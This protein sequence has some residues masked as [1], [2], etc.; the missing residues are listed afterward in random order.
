MQSSHIPLH[1]I[2]L[3]TFKTLKTSSSFPPFPSLK[4]CVLPLFISKYYPLFL[5]PYPSPHFY[6]G[7]DPSY[8][9]LGPNLSSKNVNF[10]FPLQF[11]KLTKL[12]RG[13]SEGRYFKNY[14]LFH[15]FL[16]C[17][18]W[19]PASESPG[20]LK[21]TEVGIGPGVQTLWQA[22]QSLRTLL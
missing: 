2:F 4:V 5:Y 1:P 6:P 22:L 18:L 15:T 17:G 19:T 16:K 13:R 14:S 8:F 12:F 21:A 10:F 9:L 3:G 20:E 7:K 11:M